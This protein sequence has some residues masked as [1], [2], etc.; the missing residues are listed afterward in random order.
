MDGSVQRILFGVVVAVTIGALSGRHPAAS[1]AGAAPAVQN[2]SE[3][4]NPDRVYTEAQAKR[5]EEVFTRSCGSCHGPREFASRLF[6]LSWAGRTLEEFY[7][8]IRTTMPGDMP[9]SLT[10]QEYADV[11]AHVLQLHQFQAGDTELPPDA[12]G[13]QKIKFPTEP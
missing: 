6:Q 13:M 8:K 11:A 3:S 2:G 4:G 9:G 7:T 1:V 10:E 12:A 5:G